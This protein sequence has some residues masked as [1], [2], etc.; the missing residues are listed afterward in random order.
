MKDGSYGDVIRNISPQDID[1]DAREEQHKS[2]LP[3]QNLA[4]ISGNDIPQQVN[5]LAHDVPAVSGN[6]QCAAANPLQLLV[7]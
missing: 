6:Q 5:A 2:L 1:D 3:F 7:M 4:E